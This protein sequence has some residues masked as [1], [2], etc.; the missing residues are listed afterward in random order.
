[1]PCQS[2][3]IERLSGMNSRLKFAVLLKSRSLLTLTSTASQTLRNGPEVDRYGGIGSRFTWRRGISKKTRVYKRLDRTGRVKWEEAIVCHLPSTKSDH[4]P[5][6][7]SLDPGSHIKSERKLF[8]FEA[9]WTLHPNFEEG[10]C[11]TVQALNSL[12]TDLTAWNRN[13]FRNIRRR[14]AKLLVRLV[15]IQRALEHRPH[16]ELLK[17]EARLKKELDLTLDQEKTLWYQKSREKWIRLGDKVWQT[18]QEALE[19]LAIN[20]FTELYTLP[21]QEMNFFP[22]ISGGFLRIS[23]DTLDRISSIPSNEEIWKAH[24]EMGS[25][26]AP[27]S[28][29]FQ[30]VFFKTCWHLVGESVTTFIRDFF[31]LRSLEGIVNDII[32]ALIGKVAKLEWINQFRPISLCNVIYKIITKTQASDERPY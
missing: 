28:D 29:G 7:L 32:I 8:R 15:G 6:L 31:S 3:K 12:R 30:P 22:M 16:K 18:Y 2:H 24:K 1:M 11:I 14:K 10:Q 21:K 17:L 25:F 9:A 20:F 4:N 27:G 19:T 23:E 26:K 13:V 5:L